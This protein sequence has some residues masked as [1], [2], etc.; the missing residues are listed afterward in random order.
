MPVNIQ[1]SFFVKHVIYQGSQL[2]RLF[3]T[4]FLAEP[5]STEHTWYDTERGNL[6]QCY[7]D[8]LD[9]D[10]SGTEA[11]TLQWEAGDNYLSHGTALQTFLRL[12][13]NIVFLYGAVG[14]SSNSAVPF[15]QVLWN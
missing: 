15:E 9:T 13:P 3:S 7:C 4:Q 2:L 8:H 11:G 5:I 10:W 14:V 6:S 1:L 12:P